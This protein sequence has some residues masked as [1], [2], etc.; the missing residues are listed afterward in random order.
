[1]HSTK[2]KGEKGSRSKKNRDNR[3]VL[4]KNVFVGRL[5]PQRLSPSAPPLLWCA[6]V[7]SQRPAARLVGPPSRETAL[8][9]NAPHLRSTSA[10]SSCAPWRAPRGAGNKLPT[11]CGP[12]KHGG[13]DTERQPGTATVFN[14]RRALCPARAPQ[15]AN[16]VNSQSL[17]EAKRQAP[18]V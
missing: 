14:H 7:L 18:Y 17:Q 1:M 6:G 13:G 2:K 5:S 16:A 8:P 4:R 3:I 11:D 9:H 10:R 15:A 12:P